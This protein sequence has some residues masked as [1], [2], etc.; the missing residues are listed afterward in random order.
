MAPAYRDRRARRASS[1][2]S[3]RLPAVMIQSWISSSSRW[4]RFPLPLGH[5]DA[6]GES[7][8]HLAPGRTPG[9]LH[10]AV[11][12]VGGQHHVDR[13]AAVLRHRRAFAPAGRDDRARRPRRSHGLQRV[14]VSCSRRRAGARVTTHPWNIRPRDRERAQ[15]QGL[16][17]EYADLPSG[18]A[19]NGIMERERL[20]RIGAEPSL[21]ARP[22]NDRGQSRHPG[23]V[24]VR[25]L[26][27][28]DRQDQKMARFA[29]RAA[30]AGCVPK[31][32]EKK[33]EK[34]NATGHPRLPGQHSPTNAMGTGWE[35][36]PWRA[37]QRAPAC[38]TLR[39]RR[40]V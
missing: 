37:T 15:H 14:P 21:P 9:R 10:N 20:Q 38:P 12:H 40:P 35:R 17:T 22:G 23:Q 3:K 2:R 32:S 18:F 11:L 28:Q 36:M 1:E 8:D 16:A 25:V 6:A 5:R 31:R 7:S 34:K 30:T 39:R 4:S 26:R 27:T 19:R 29:R 24:R 13:Q 33:R